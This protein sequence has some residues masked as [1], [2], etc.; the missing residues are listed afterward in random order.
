MRLALAIVAA[1]GVVVGWCPEPG[2]AASPTCL[3]V[4]EA[5]RVPDFFSFRARLQTAVAERNGDAV[6]AVVDP[7]IK[8]GFD[9]EDGIDAFKR[10]WRI[11]EPGS[12]LWQELGALLALGGVFEGTD[13]FVAPYTFQCDDDAFEGAAV[14]GANVNVR[15]GPSAD[16]T[17]IGSLT[18][19]MVRL[20]AGFPE[21]EWIEVA[22]DGRKGFVSSRW[23]RSPIDYRAYFARSHG[24]WRM[25]M[26][27]AGD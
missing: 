15:T 11:D 26:L 17:V 10:T 2:M 4:D 8:N 22:L 21:R 19:S 3:P 18:F 24:R 6:L 9:A 12:R 1:V 16:A 27:V 5:A 20:A 23:L 7:K 25:T 14:M 13:A